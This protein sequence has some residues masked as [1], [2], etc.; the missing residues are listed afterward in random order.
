MLK[1]QSEIV[2]NGREGGIINF[3]VLLTKVFWPRIATDNA[4][5]RAI[6]VIRA[7]RG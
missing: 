1:A 2:G 3:L 7:I 4:D 6:P 5:V